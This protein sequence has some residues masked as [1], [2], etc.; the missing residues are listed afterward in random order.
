MERD[1]DVYIFPAFNAVDTLAAL[2][3][4]AHERPVLLFTADE[5]RLPT[6]AEVDQAPAHAREL[7]SDGRPESDLHLRTSQSSAA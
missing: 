1:T 4:T 2:R 3:G 5:T 7:T 6:D